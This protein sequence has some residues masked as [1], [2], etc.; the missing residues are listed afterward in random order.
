MNVPL[1]LFLVAGILAVIELARSD[2]R[3]L[4]AWALVCIAAGLLWG[5]IPA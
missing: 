1:I 3:S 4:T 2:L 5:L